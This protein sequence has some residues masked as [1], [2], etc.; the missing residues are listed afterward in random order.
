MAVMATVRAWP[1]FLIPLSLLAHRCDGFSRAA[2]QLRG[3]LVATSLSSAAAPVEDK[4]PSPLPSIAAIAN[5]DTDNIDDVRRARSIARRDR[6]ARWQAAAAEDQEEER[7]LQD[8]Y[9]LLLAFVPA[10]LA[11]LTWEPISFGLSELLDMYGVVK[12]D[13]GFA[14]NLLRPTITGVFMPVVSIALATLVSTTV[15]VLRERQVSLRAFINKEACELRLI[16]RAVFGMFGTRQ[17]AGRRARALALVCGYVEQLMT[18]CDRGAVEELE[19]RQLSGGIS[20]NELDRLSAMLHGVDGAAA[21]RQGSVGVADELIMSLNRHRSD[22]VALL[23][24]VFPAIHWDVLVGLSLSIIAAFLLTS[25]Q[26]ML[27]YL[28]S[29]QLRFLFATIVGV[30]SSTATLCWDLSDPFSGTFSIEGAGTQLADLRLCLRE[31]VREALEEDGAMASSTRDFFNSVLKGDDLL[32]IKWS[33]KDRGNVDLRSP[34]RYGLLRTIYFHLLT[35]PFGANVR[36]FGDFVAWLATLFGR[37]ARAILKWRL[38]RRPWR[39]R[40]KLA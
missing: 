28:N 21:S 38:T 8:N 15:N 31:D 10:L 9:F 2:P 35:G 11:F 3:P 17:H 4:G 26:Q 23:L 33:E 7:D 25:N 16:R 13:Q 36:A 27:Q 18:E 34:S 29:I 37:R 39:R 6:L 19:E 32:S 12:S 20:T 22:R 40:G 24:S 14:N 5:L 30:C 1:S